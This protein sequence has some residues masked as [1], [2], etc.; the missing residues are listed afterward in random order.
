MNNEPRVVLDGEFEKVIERDDHYYVQSKFDR[1]CI[2]PYTVSSDGLLSDIGVVETW[3]EEEKQ[4]SLTLVTGY[5][6]Q[7]DET[8]LVGANRVLYE[9]TRNNLTDA[10]K[11]M[12]LG[13]VYNSLTSD[14]PI[15]IYAVNVSDL[16]IKEEV[17]NPDLKKN[18]KLMESSRVVQSDDLLFLGAFTRLFNFFYTNSLK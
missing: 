1:V 15:K 5:L 10:S 7:D 9:I 16:D 12:Y 8:N 18:F 3:N 4:K 14:S 2:V 13:S 17:Q 11:W 6:N